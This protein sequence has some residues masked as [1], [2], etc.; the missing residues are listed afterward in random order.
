VV[1]AMLTGA[2]RYDLIQQAG[3]AFPKTTDDLVK[4]LQ[5]VNKKER[6][7]GMSPTTT[8]AGPLFPICRPLAASVFR[9]PPDDLFLTL[10]TRSGA[11]G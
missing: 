7:A 8:M 2:S 5:A 9:A 10:D 1:E 4:V 3:L 11:G 6:V